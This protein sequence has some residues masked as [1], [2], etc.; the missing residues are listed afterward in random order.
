MSK[1]AHDIFTL[2][3]N[4]LETN[5]QPKDVIIGFFKASETTKQV[6]VK[7]LA[8]FKLIHVV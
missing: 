6:F 1:G 3:V 4:F 8:E 7:S 2:V 5:W